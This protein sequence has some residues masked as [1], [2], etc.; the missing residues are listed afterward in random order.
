M[1]GCQAHASGNTETVDLIILTL[2]KYVELWPF[3]LLEAT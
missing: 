3:M 1:D 2:I